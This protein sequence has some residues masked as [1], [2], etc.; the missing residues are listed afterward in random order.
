MSTYKDKYLKYKNK[1]TF[2]KK[3][4]G[5]ET[6]PPP[7]ENLPEITEDLK[8]FLTN[9]IM[10][11]PVVFINI[12]HIEED[13]S[14]K[15][16]KTYDRDSLIKHLQQKGI[17]QFQIINSFFDDVEVKTALK[18]YH[19]EVERVNKKREQYIISIRE[20]YLQTI[21]LIQANQLEPSS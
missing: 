18:N 11:E 4:I 14:I 16:G 9:E 3:Q 10:K 13:Q 7:E 19:E 6:L 20:E 8:C 1:Y 2:L 5:G 17:P 21:P 15:N 12:Y